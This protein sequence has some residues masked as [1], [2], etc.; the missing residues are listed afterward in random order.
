VRARHPGTRGAAASARRS[1]PRRPGQPGRGEGPVVRK[2][3]P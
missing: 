1:L 2:A 3:R